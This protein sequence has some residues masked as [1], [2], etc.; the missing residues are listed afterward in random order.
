[1]IL[2]CTSSE[3]GR[4]RLKKRLMS[5]KVSA[6]L[7]NCIPGINT[8][9]T[10]RNC[11][12]VFLVCW[13]VGSLVRWFVGSLVRWFVGSLVRWYFGTLVLCFFVTIHTGPKELGQVFGGSIFGEGS[14]LNRDVPR[15]ASCV[16][17]SDGVEC[18]LISFANYDSIVTE[19]L[20]RAL[21]RDFEQ[22]DQGTF[23]DAKLSELE[24]LRDL[25]KGAFGK[26][27]LVRHSV[28]GRVC[29]IKEVSIAK[30]DTTK[31]GVYV[32]RECVLLF[33]LRHPFMIHIFGTFLSPTH[34]YMAMD[35]IL[36][37]E[38]LHAIYSNYDIVSKSASVR[39]YI[40]QIVDVLSYLHRLY[41][42]YRDIKPENLLIGH[43]GYLTLIDFSVAKKTSSECFTLIGTPEYTAPEVFR[44]TGHSTACDWWS[45]GI[46]MH[47]LSVG[48]P[49]FQGDNVMEIMEGE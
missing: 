2:V 14:L 18:A 15:S 39:F 21:K 30:A 24:I 27:Y 7:D 44:M 28:T 19:D 9:C 35:P 47:E 25:G 12:L 45:V 6:R 38:L 40:G 16:A 46:L 17:A 8:T 20:T 1:M 29:A 43:D 32:A 3:E 48:E 4:L 22:R 13:F 10:H 26:V 11:F 33:D 36:G 49:P 31:N 23:S 41:I 5:K 34:V 42:V 37:G